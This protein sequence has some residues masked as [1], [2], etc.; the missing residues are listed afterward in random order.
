[1]AE[2]L[3]AWLATNGGHW[4]AGLT[5][6]ACPGGGHGIFS[7]AEISE[8]EQLLSVPAALL[9]TAGSAASRDW[10]ESLVESDKIALALLTER[11]KGEASLW[12]SWILHGI[13]ENFD[14]LPFTWDMASEPGSELC[15]P[16]LKA[17]VAAQRSDAL[18]R[19]AA[20]VAVQLLSDGSAPDAPMPPSSQSYLWALSA[21]ESRGMH[22]D[23][24]ELGAES[25]CICPVGDLLNH[26]AADTSNVTGEY[27][28]T[29]AAYNF[30]AT[31]AIT[32]GEELLLHYGPH[33]DA[34]LVQS[35]GFVLPNNPYARVL[36]APS[37]DDEVKACLDLAAGDTEWLAEHGLDVDWAIEPT[38][39]SWTLLR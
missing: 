21:L 12:H 8:G 17:R 32:A 24:P 10:P 37:D 38:G 26:A 22:L 23:A 29:A 4:S 14:C 27:D 11:A 6:R 36:V 5:I 31:R 18:E 25:V 1:M 34:T 13:P 7:T 30:R 39:P 3:G 33:D 2:K 15:C 28:P 9:L 20:L 19:R 35:Y 16:S